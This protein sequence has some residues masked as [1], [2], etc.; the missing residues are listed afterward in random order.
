MGK[1]NKPQNKENPR[2][3]TRKKGKVN[4]KK[5]WTQKE[6]T[7]LLKLID[8]HGPSHWSS[9]ARSIPSRQGKQCRER[10][11]NHLNPHIKKGDW[12]TPE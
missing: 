5:P 7:L 12:E 9:I 8:K 6:D 1:S 10:W 4:H 11:H 3:I 2:P